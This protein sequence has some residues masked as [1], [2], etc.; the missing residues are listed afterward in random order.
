M[1]AEDISRNAVSP[2]RATTPRATR[3]RGRCGTR[4]TGSVRFRFVV[5]R[6][7]LSANRCPP[8]IMPAA[9]LWPEYA[10]ACSRLRRAVARPRAPLGRNRVPPQPRPGLHDWYRVIVLGEMLAEE[11]AHQRIV[12]RVHGRKQVMLG[13]IGGVRVQQVA[14]RRHQHGGRSGGHVATVVDRLEAVIGEEIA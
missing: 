12:F 5:W 1:S 14:E 13:V 2:S 9:R 4:P 10:L 11:A 8:R 7:F 3:R 6:I